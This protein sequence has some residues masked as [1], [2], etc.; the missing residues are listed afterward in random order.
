MAP[1]RGINQITPIFNSD[2]LH[3]APPTWGNL[4]EP[5]Q[6]GQDTKLNSAVSGLPVGTGILRTV[7]PG[8][9]KLRKAK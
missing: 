4:F 1:V 9:L 5:H 7:V 8:G 3:M 2:L 6:L